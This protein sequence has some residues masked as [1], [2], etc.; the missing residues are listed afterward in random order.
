MAYLPI[1]VDVRGRNCVVIGG[2]EIAERKV[3]ALLEAEAAVTVVSPELT[4]GLAALAADGAV[5]HRAR[6]YR[7]GD[8]AGASFAFAA[9]GDAATAAAASR[10]AAVA[11]ILINVADAPELC[12]FIAPAIVRRGALT[13]AISTGGASPAAATAIRERLEEVFGP[14]YGPWLELMRAARKWLRDR[15]TES[16][17]RARRLGALARSDLRGAI[18]RGDCARAEALLREYLGGGFVEL[19]LDR[20]ALAYQ[21]ADAPRAGAADGR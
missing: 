12:S 19:G 6:P 10:E 15:A 20:F 17:D 9:T 16:A 2:G 18:A 7:H 14:E 5:S 4:A 8:L 3:R 21:S 1:F 11:G 13:I